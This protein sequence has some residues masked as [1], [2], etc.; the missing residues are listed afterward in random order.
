[1]LDG[2]AQLMAWKLSLSYANPVGTATL[3]AA[4]FSEVRYRAGT[5]VSFNVISGHRDADETACPGNA[6]YA[7]LPQLRQEVLT[8]MGA[9]LVGPAITVPKPRTVAGN[10]SVHVVAGMIAAGTWQILVQDSTGAEVRTIA[11]SGSAID[12]TWD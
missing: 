10:G 12:T 7:L 9:G 3:T 4:P 6:A 8:D 5:K 11:G 2:T 1:M